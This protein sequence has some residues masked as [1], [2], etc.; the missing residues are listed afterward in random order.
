MRTGLLEEKMRFE[1]KAVSAGAG[2][3][4]AGAW[5]QEGADQFA[6][7]SPSDPRAEAAI[8][9]RREGRTPYE[10]TVWD[11][12]LARSITGADR[13]VRI[14]DGAAFN[15]LAPGVPSQRQAGQFLTFHCELGA[16]DG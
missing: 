7:F 10:V 13:I 15:V 4:K 3:L 12:A 14:S 9:A 6:D 2:G 1:R 11:S 16:A 5:A 8:A